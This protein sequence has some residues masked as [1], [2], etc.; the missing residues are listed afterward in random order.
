M[1][2]VTV[3]VCDPSPKAR[4][5]ICLLLEQI[6][7]RGVNITCTENIKQTLEITEAGKPDLVFVDLTISDVEGYSICTMLE[8]SRDVY[9][10]PVILM[11]YKDEGVNPRRAITVKGRGFLS[12][13]IQIISLKKQV[14]KILREREL[15]AKIIEKHQDYSC[16]SCLSK[17]SN[18]VK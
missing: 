12:K 11:A 7:I 4:E 13:P 15:E 1:K 14:A 9:N 18:D 17:G 3:V 2:N 5:N 16:K 6:G 10:V 8:K